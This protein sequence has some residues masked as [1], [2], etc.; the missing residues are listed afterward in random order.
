[1]GLN[2]PL[3]FRSRFINQHHPPAFKTESQHPLNRVLV[4][5]REDGDGGL[6]LGGH[7]FTTYKKRMDILGFDHQD[8][9]RFFEEQLG[10][11]VGAIDY[12]RGSE[13]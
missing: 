4:K 13:N 12:V 5:R 9:F 2:F 1:M 6:E 11:G 10:S 3:D 8:T 7:R